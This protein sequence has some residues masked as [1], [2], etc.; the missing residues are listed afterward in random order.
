MSRNQTLVARSTKERAEILGGI[1]PDQCGSDGMR[2][3]SR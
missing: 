1:C 2:N 3:G